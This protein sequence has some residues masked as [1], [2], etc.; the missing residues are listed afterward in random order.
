MSFLQ[1]KLDI[2][3]H[4]RNNWTD[5]HICYEND[6]FTGDT[7]WVRISMQNAE[8]FQVTLGDNPYFRYIGVLFVQIFIK[9][10]VGS[11]RALFLADKVEAIFR[12]LTLGKIQFK[13]PTIDKIPV[14]EDWYQVNVN[15]PFYRGS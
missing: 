10:D 7:E 8:S 6:Q 12:N 15:I 5:T 3:N 14:T 9:P 11:G 13:V 1:E 4:F 2:E